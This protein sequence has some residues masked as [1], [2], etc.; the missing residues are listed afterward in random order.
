MSDKFTEAEIETIRKFFAFLEVNKWLSD[1][2][3]ITGF[4]DDGVLVREFRAEMEYD[5][6]A[7]E[8]DDTFIPLIALTDPEE[9]E[10]QAAAEKEEQRREEARR[11]AETRR[12]E[13][14]QQR[15]TYEKLKA[16]FG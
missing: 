9:Y 11:R 14:A 6:C 7:L 12:A 4:N 2:E 3:A 10:R 8:T 5:W 1:C 15:A 16:K 13:E